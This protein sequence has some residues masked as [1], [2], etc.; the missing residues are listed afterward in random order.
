MHHDTTPEENRARL[1]FPRSLLARSGFAATDPLLAADLRE[2]TTFERAR[3]VVA[4]HAFHLWTEA[5]RT[6]AGPMD[7]RPLYWTRLMLSARLRTWRP[8][9]DLSQ[10]QRT[11]LLHLWEK[12]S[13]GLTDPDFPPGEKWLRVVVTGFDPFHLDQDLECS[14]PS[15]AAALALHGWTFPVGERTAVVRSALFPVRW[16]AFTHGMVEEAL[17]PRHRVADAVIT[18]SRGRP[19]RF[20]LEVHNGAWRGGGIDNLEASRTGPIP[21]PEGPGPQW[22][23]TSLPVEHIVRTVGGEFTVVANTEVTEIPAGEGEPVT[24][25]QGPGA[26][27]SARSGGGGDYLSNEIAYRNTLLRDRTGSGALSGHVHLPKTSR[28]HEHTPVLERTRAIVAAA[29]NG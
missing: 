6:P 28:P 19:D 27:S 29:L 3:R 10:V 1:P 2:A 14:N 18:L 23:R 5:T 20:D 17:A 21:L 22:T 16:D 12:T 9:F 7:D 13:R 26:G 8:T 15:G 24:R 4:S 25:P 11:E